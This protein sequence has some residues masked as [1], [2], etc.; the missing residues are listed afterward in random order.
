MKCVDWGFPQST[1][2]I[3]SYSFLTFGGT[4]R[5]SWASFGRSVWRLGRVTIMLCF[6]TI[7]GRLEGCA[8]GTIQSFHT[9]VAPEVREDIAKPCEYEL[10]ILS[11]S[12][13]IRALF[14]VFERGPEVQHFYNEPEVAAFAKKHDL[15]MLMPHHCASKDHEEMDVDPEKGLGRALFT[16]I[17]QFSLQTN[18]PEL[19]SAPLIVLGFSGAGALAGRLVGFAPDRMAAAILSHAGQFPPLNLDTIKLSGPALGVP[20]LIL[21]GGKDKVVGTELAYAYFSKYW[22]LGAPWLFATQN[23]A[24]HFCTSDATDLILAWLDIVLENRRLK[25][26]PAVIESTH[27]YYAFFRKKTNGSLDSGDVPLAE[28]VDLLFQ[29]PHE[30]PPQD[31]TP[32]GWLPSEQVALMWEKFATLPDHHASAKH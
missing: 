28:S 25:Q 11:E 10:E 14:V 24:A 17:D 23:D 26:T 2:D 21:V 31:E 30:A 6:I 12:K 7:V 4:V 20:E 18:H 27:G 16:A 9:T 19:R 29:R 13:T 1:L 32:A 15:A 8:Q 5:L 22:R 3:S